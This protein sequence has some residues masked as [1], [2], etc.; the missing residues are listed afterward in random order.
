MEIAEE[1]SIDP[2]TIAERT[3]IH[4]LGTLGTLK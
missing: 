1:W 4:Y 2:T 3:D